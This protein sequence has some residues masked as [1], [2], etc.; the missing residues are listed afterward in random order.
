MEF[1]KMHGAANDFV[2]VDARNLNMDWP[3]LAIEVCNRHLGIGCDSL[4]IL[5][6]SHKADIAMRT[7]DTDGSESETCGNGIRCVARYCLEK[8]L[9]DPDAEEVTI[10]TLFTIN[11]VTFEKKDGKVV[12]FWANMGQPWLAADKIPVILHAAKDEHS[13]ISCP[14][15][16][17]GAEL[18]L[19]LVSMGNPHAVHFTR[20]PVADFPMS[21]IGPLVEN[22]PIFPNRVNFEVARVLDDK[23]IEARVWER[24]VGETLACGS[25]TCAITVASKLLGYTGSKV[26]IHLRGGVLHGIWNGNR[27]VV[28]GGPAEIVYEGNWPVRGI[29]DEDSPAHGKYPALSLCRDK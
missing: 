25:G 7:F 21:E 11:H 24:G 26:D 22:L 23:N 15:K 16:V 20:E 12:K 5:L 6:N 28:I 18:T 10:E 8:G 9:V 17:G 13:L 29:V 1:T 2:M 27:E 3:K 14:V 19:N 4:I